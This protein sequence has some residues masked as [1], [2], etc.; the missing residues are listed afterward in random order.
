MAKAA[1]FLFIL[2][3][4]VAG[5]AFAW[6]DYTNVVVA[7]LVLLDSYPKCAAQI[8]EG[9]LLPSQNEVVDTVLGE[10]ANLHCDTLTCPA[11]DPAYCQTDVKTCASES[12][13]GKIKS[14]AKVDCNCEQAKLLAESITYYIAKYDPMNLMVREKCHFE[15]DDTVEKAMRDGATTWQ[16]DFN[17]SGPV[18]TF[19]FSS[20]KYSEMLYNAKTFAFAEA[21]TG[22]QPWFCYDLGQPGQG[23][24]LKG[25]GELCAKSDDCESGHCNNNVCCNAEI[26]CASPG[27]KGFPCNQGEKCGGDYTCMAINAQNGDKCSYD[28]ECVTGNCKPGS[29]TSANKYCCNAGNNY[30]CISNSDCTSDQECKN[31][32]CSSKIFAGNNTNHSGNGGTTIPP[33]KGCLPFAILLAALG[34]LSMLGDRIANKS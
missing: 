4:A 31:N 22:T 18:R 15:F 20:Q 26:C 10:A 13:A 9:A 8:E 28:E 30:C 6:S 21:H 5:M 14:S 16:V 27:V 19:S 25:T 24:V 34:G 33:E 3:L 32:I 7:K 12:M 29:A 23:G 11:Y 17:C 1:L 2:T